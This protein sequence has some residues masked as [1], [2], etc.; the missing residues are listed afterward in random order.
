MQA[1]GYV[2]CY[3]KLSYLFTPNET[4]FIQHI[5]E[6]SFLK[7]HG[8]DTDWAKQTYIKRMGLKETSFDKCVRKFTEMKLLHKW[9]NTQK[10]KVYYSWNWP[11]YEK[12]IRILSSTNNIDALIN[13]ADTYF[14]KNNRSI[15]SITEDEIR[16]LSRHSGSDLKKAYKLNYS[17][18]PVENS[19]PDTPDVYLEILQEIQHK[20][21]GNQETLNLIL[22]L[23]NFT[24][25]GNTDRHP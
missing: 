14:K 16:M 3:N 23:L 2:K 12:L 10:N 13:F 11:V 25:Q 6:I 18:L 24:C 20:I 9:N 19:D 4:R 5:V 1:A 21:K 7:D 15:E 8:Y 17:S 22:R